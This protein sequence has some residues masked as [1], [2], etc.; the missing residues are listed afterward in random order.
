MAAGQGK[1]V[2]LELLVSKEADIN[3]KDDNGVSVQSYLTQT[4]SDFEH[5]QASFFGYHLAICHSFIGE[6]ANKIKGAYTAVQ[7][8]ITGIQ[9]STY[10]THI[11]L[12]RKVHCMGG[13]DQ[14]DSVLISHSFKKN[15]AWIHWE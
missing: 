8:Q 13:H 5:K 4:T 6:P 15:A 11:K 1:L 10:P 14:F 7:V 2:T 9:Q 12:Y 3:S